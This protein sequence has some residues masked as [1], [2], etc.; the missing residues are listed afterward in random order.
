MPLKALLD[1]LDG[2]TDE[3][4]A[5]YKPIADGDFA[6]K[7]V[8]DVEGVDGLALENVKG[9]TSALGAVKTENA[10]LK[11]SI[12]GFKGLDAKKV[13]DQ[14]KEL[15]KLKQINPENEADKLAEVK[16][17]GKI[18]ELNKQHAKAI[19]KA[20]KRNG[21]LITQIEDLLI[22]NE[23]T[24][25]IVAEKG[26]PR[27][28]MPIVRDRLKVNEG[29]DGKFS[30]QVL[31]ER[32]DQAYTVR[33]GNAVPASI[34]DLVITLK[35]DPSLG[36][37]FEASGSSGTGS[38]PNDRRIQAGAENPWLKGPTW[39]FTKQMMIT[40]QDPTLAAA[41][42]AQAGIED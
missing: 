13:R 1:N 35:A 42:K 3:V 9:L 29:E 26:N 11:A 40:R 24:T 17:Q 16:A 19:E 32:G 28:L 38:S 20:T 21:D 8:L 5:F 15:E 22:V 27:L 39:N 7:F 23:A 33:E 36:Q 31:N 10:E 4:K 25:A 12:E 2:L 37:A 6:G 34:R 14:L 18:D 30:I 41:M